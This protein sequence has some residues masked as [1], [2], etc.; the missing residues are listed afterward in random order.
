L[1]WKRQAGGV[2]ELERRLPNRV[3]FATKV[4][5]EGHGVRLELRLTNGTD[6]KLTDLRVQICVLLK[7]ANGF[8]QQSNDNKVFAKPF[9]ACRQTSGKRWIIAACEPCVRVWANQACPCLHSDPQ[10]PDCTPG[11]TPRI[12]GW[13][14]FYEGDD[15]Q[16]ELR[17]LQP[18][19]FGSKNAE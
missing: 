4:V 10:I 11:E 18:I 17:R 1:E 12:R 16:A 5:P 9:T 2:L 15:I 3:T 7:A 14:S 8:E 13:L 19:A 6:H